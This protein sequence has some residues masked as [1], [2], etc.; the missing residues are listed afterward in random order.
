VRRR[1][2]ADEAGLRLALED[3]IGDGKRG[4]LGYFRRKTAERLER[5]RATQRAGRFGLV[6][7]AATL[8]VLFFVGV[9]I[10]ESARAPLVYL[11]GCV[12]LAIGVRRAYAAA[13]AEFELIKQYEF[14][15]RI[16][17][18]ARRRVDA[19]DD[20]DERRR[21]LKVLG[22]AALE[23]HAEWILSTASARSTRAK[24]CVSA[25]RSRGPA[26]PPPAGRVILWSNGPAARGRPLAILRPMRTLRG[27]RMAYDRNNIFARILRGEIPPTGSWR[28]STRSPSW[29]SCRR[30]TATR[31]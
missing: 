20:D 2:D 13:T 24:S 9:G 8:L 3:W 14:M 26:R 29:T 4:Q 19:A 22:D 21:V 17:G 10:P 18:N 1:A 16:F 25:D 15:T 23:E 28:T 12:L 31:W 7:S 27:G 30:R 11:V 5:N 6:A